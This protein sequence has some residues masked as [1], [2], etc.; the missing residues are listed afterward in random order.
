MPL[1]GDGRREGFGDGFAAVVGPL[2]VGQ[3][4]AHGDGYDASTQPNGQHEKAGRHSKAAE[5]AG[6]V[7]G[8]QI[9]FKN[10]K[11]HQVLAE[12]HEGEERPAK[13]SCI[14]TEGAVIEDERRGIFRRG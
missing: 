2:E 6:A 5:R 9:D 4:R 8:A 1:A 3:K 13:R 7:L 11:G 14:E 12:R 10:G